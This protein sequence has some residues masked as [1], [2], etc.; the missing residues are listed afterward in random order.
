MLQI[1]WLAEILPFSLPIVAASFDSGC[2]IDNS[3]NQK[4]KT[5]SWQ[6]FIFIS[7]RPDEPNTDILVKL[8]VHK[9][10]LC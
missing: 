5:A 4:V 8:S 2:I 7:S 3:E 6:Y 9:L 10:F 1:C